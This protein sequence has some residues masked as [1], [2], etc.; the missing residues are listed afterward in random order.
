MA[1]SEEDVRKIAKLARLRLEP[2]EVTLYQGQLGKILDSMAELAELDTSKVEPTISVLGVTNVLRED[3]PGP[4][5]A[6]EKLLDNA[7]RREGSFFKVPKV[8]E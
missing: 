7:P 3:V 2:E 8:I 5:A 1:I 6:V 4:F